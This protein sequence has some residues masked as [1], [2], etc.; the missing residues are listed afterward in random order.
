M[1]VM[2]ISVMS[3][4]FLMSLLYVD[5]VHGDC[6]LVSVMILVSLKGQCTRYFDS[7]FFHK[8]SSPS[9]VRHA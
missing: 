5:G 3:V 4:R 9:P 1:P 6:G 2:L 8:T 7:R